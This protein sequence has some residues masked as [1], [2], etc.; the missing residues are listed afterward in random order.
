M[1]PLYEKNCLSVSFIV[2]LR[3][4]VDHTCIFLR[5]FSINLFQNIVE[6]IVIFHDIY[7]YNVELDNKKHPQKWVVINHYYDLLQ[8]WIM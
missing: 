6:D 3:I 2:N 8:I 4:I 7:I 1:K 5:F